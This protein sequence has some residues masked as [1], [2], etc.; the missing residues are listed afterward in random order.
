MIYSSFDLFPLWNSLRVAAIAI[1]VIFFLGIFLAYYISKLPRILK[2]IIDVILTLPLV[3]PPT[4]C[5]YFLILIF[6]HNTPIGKFLLEIG[7]P[8][9]MNWRGA[10][11]ASI[12]V[13]F[14]LMY[15]TVRASFETFDENLSDAGKTL[16]LSNSYIFWRIRLPA[17]RNGIIA[18]TVLAFARALGEYGATSMFVGYIQGK[19]ATISTAV[20]F[21]WMT[22]HEDLAFIWVAI[23]IAIAAIVLLTIN[24]FERDVKGAR[25]GVH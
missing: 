24:F 23:N 6:G 13:A 14:P 10:I 9:F 20:Y 19:T 22:D 25:K 1:V 11:L 18:G 5:G 21:Y 16:G 3:L 12:M 2:G 4:V 8:F 17:C 7:L 15:R